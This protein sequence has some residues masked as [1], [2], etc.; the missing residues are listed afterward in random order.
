MID[1]LWM[2]EPPKPRKQSR[3]VSNRKPDKKK[4][5]DRFIAWSGREFR[6][7]ITKM[8]NKRS[9]RIPLK[10]NSSRTR[11]T[12]YQQNYF[13]Q[14]PSSAI[15]STRFSLSKKSLFAWNVVVLVPV[16]DAN[17]RSVT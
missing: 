8:F 9:N 13:R 14:Y 11:R 1:D 7:Q 16:F 12:V 6:F 3:S 15:P 17:L 2:S 4:H 10:A 5:F